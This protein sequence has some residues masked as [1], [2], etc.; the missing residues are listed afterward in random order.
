M[1]KAYLFDVDG[2][3]TD[4]ETKKVE[5]P[6]TFYELVKRVEQGNIVGLITGRSMIFVVEKILVPLEKMINNKQLLQDIFVAA[7]YGGVL[8]SYNKNG[9]R[10]TNV[11]ENTCLPS[12][13][14]QEI[15]GLVNK[16]PYSE[17]MFYDETKQTMATIELLP[18]EKRYR[19]SLEIFKGAQKQLVATLIKILKSHRVENQFKIDQTRIATDIESVDVGKTFATRKI[20]ELMSKMSVFPE[21]YLAFGDSPVDYEIFEEL[22][23]LGKETQFIFVGES[24]H[25]VGKPTTGLIRTSKPLDKGTLEFLQK[26]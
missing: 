25:L 14:Q 7:E 15:R 21:K 9:S 22:R 12:V 19:K 5:H 1:Q 3:L 8:A 4:P 17:T 18:I 13:I 10:R 24:K 20:V 6:E 26:E 11:K 16:P 2:V 23:H